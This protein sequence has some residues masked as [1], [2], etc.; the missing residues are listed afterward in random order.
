VLGEFWTN[1][2]RNIPVLS[3]DEG[4]RRPPPRGCLP[5]LSQLS[6]ATFSNQPPK[7]FPISSSVAVPIKLLHQFLS[8]INIPFQ[9]PSCLHAGRMI[10]FEAKLDPSATPQ[11]ESL[12]KPRSTQ[13]EEVE[14]RSQKRRQPI[15]HSSHSAMSQAPPQ[16]T[17]SIPCNIRTSIATADHTLP[18]ALED[19]IS[20]KKG[21]RVTREPKNNLVNFGF[22]EGHN[23]AVVPVGFP[24]PGQIVRPLN[25][26]GISGLPDFRDEILRGKGCEISC[27]LEK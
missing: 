5:E 4:V 7:F 9:H 27:A 17:A 1:W 26:E 11:A 20:I 13:L 8:S 25:F 15:S 10:G 18:S 22:R 23:P 12:P 2:S 16:Q 21:E 14:S 3:T 19:G 6:S 24:Q